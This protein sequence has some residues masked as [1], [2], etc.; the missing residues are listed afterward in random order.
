MYVHIGEGKLW[1]QRSNV[2]LTPMLVKSPK[3]LE[4]ISAKSI[5]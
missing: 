2:N 5:I 3:P 1:E 4:I